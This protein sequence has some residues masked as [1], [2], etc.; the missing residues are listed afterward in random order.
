MTSTRIAGK[1]V[2]AW[3]K[4]IPQLTDLFSLKEVFWMNPTKL[5]FEE[6]STLVS[7]TKEVS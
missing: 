6:A 4:E 7:Y 2:V 1:T 3:E 5:P